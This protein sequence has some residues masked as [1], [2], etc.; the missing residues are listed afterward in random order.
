ME[1]RFF[2]LLLTTFLAIAGCVRVVPPAASP[3]TTLQPTTAPNWNQHSSWA[4]KGGIVIAQP[5]RVTMARLFWQQQQKKYVVKLAGPFNLGGIQIQGQPGRVMLI[6]AQNKPPIVATSAEQLL[7]QQLQLQ[8]PVSSLYY[9]LRALPVP[10]I[11][12]TQQRDN[13]GRLMTLQQQGW[14]IQYMSY[15]QTGAYSLPQKIE[16]TAPPLRI[17]VIIQKWQL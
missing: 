2:L 17:K 7:Q 3:T 13:T 5:Q 12:A 16:F 11:A 9:W 10:G 4:I 14:Q 8:L 1:K 6:T 15:Q